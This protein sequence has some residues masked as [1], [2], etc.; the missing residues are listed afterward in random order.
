[1]TSN[2][3]APTAA[4]KGV[5]PFRVLVVE[6]DRITFTGLVMLLKHYRFEVDV[7]QSLANAREKIARG[8]N[9]VCLDLILPDG[10]GVDL[11]Q[12]LKQTSSIPVI[13]TTAS[14]CPNRLR[15]VRNL[16]PEK[17][18][19]KPVNFLDLLDVIKRLS[20]VET[21]VEPGSDKPDF[22]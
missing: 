21:R 6:D 18:Y 10:E 5:R 2:A 17:L 8:V 11:L 9:L 12:E 1:M 3:I 7:A 4:T 16:L 22:F 20:A 13:V 14:D 15:R 19:K